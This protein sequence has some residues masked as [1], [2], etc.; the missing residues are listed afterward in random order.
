MHYFLN[1][2]NHALTAEQKADAQSRFFSK[3]FVE[4]PENLKSWWGAIPT[5]PQNICNDEAFEELSSFLKSFQGQ[6][7]AMIAGV[8]SLCAATA[9]LCENFSIVAVEAASSRESAET[10]QPDGSVRKSSVFRHVCFREYPK[11][12]FLLKR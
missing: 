8:G 5:V 12:A 9:A 7:V 4:L 3:K 11:L 2:S 6:A 1:L 10:V